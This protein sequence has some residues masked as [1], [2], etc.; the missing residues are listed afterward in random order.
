M[1]DDTVHYGGCVFGYW[2]MWGV[3]T[4]AP[5]S[6]ILK[7][8]SGSSLAAVIHVCGC[9][10]EDQLLLCSSL[11]SS[12]MRNK[13]SLFDV[14]RRWLRE[15]LPDDCA[16]RCRNRV[17]VLLR[18]LFMCQP[19]CVTEWSGKEDLIRCLLTAC[20]PFPSVYRGYLCMDCVLHHDAS[21]RR[22]PCRIVLK[23]PTKEDAMELFR[24]G[25]EDGFEF[26]N[27]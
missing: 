16:E 26:E 12:L 14:L 15:S 10:V 8:V 13:L 1:Q 4:N 27:M 18:R 24:K 23:V 2:Y 22:A 11:R 19:W 5:Q 7:C 25:V 9:S 21:T 6:R 3:M 20:S 17:H